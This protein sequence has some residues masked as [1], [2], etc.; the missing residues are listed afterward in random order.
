MWNLAAQALMGALA[1]SL[2]SLVGRGIMAAGVGFITYKGIDLAL[3]AVK[4]QVMGSVSTLGGQIVGLVGFLWIDK[5]LTL[6]FSCFVAAL[7][8]KLVGGSVKRAI[9]K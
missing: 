3:N 2:G 5:G 7:S 1:A 4:L 6:I 9:F 8:I